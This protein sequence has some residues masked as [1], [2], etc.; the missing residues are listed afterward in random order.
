MNNVSNS[1]SVCRELFS[2]NPCI[3]QPRCS[4]IRD[5]HE[6]KS[7][8]A[9]IPPTT[10]MASP[11]PSASSASANTEADSIMPLAVAAAI[12]RQ[13]GSESLRKRTGSAPRPV[14]N[15]VRS[16]TQKT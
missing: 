14:A 8:P 9:S 13:R 15:A 12:P 10:S 16:A 6:K 3:V 5:V 7:A 2:L 1:S 11:R 4:I